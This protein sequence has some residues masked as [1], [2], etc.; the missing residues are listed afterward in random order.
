M[1]K[2]VSMIISF[3][4]GKICPDTFT[5]DGEFQG[6]KKSVFFFMYKFL[7]YRYLLHSPKVK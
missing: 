6:E 3:S 4:I 1:G 5:F 7:M 2:D